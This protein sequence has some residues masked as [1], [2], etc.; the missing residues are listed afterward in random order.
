LLRNALFI[1]T[2]FVI[3]S[4]KSWSKS[5]AEAQPINAI[6]ACHPL[7]W[8]KSSAILDPNFAIPKSILLELQQQ[9]DKLLRQ[10]SHPIPT[11][12]S[13]GKIS[14]DDPLLIASRDAFKDADHAAVLGLTYRLT[15]NINY[16]D[17]A[18][19]ILLSWAEKNQPTGNPIDETRLDGMIWAYDLI[20]CDLSKQDKFLILDWFKRMKEKKIS[21]VFGKKTS[22]NNY[23]IHQLK[24]LLLLN[25]IINHQDDWQKD[26]ATAESYSRINLNPETGVSIDYRERTALYYQN[27][28]LQPW[29]EISLLT[30]CCQQS[31]KKAFSF[32]DKKIFFHQLQG[33]FSHSHAKID[34]LRA[35][36]G[37]AYAKKGKQFDKEKAAPTII[38][39]Y[40]LVRE[41]PDAKLWLIQEQTKSSPKMSFLKSRRLLWQP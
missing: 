19:N 24:M 33:E 12:S 16:L 18:K 34:E 20:A 41:H 30:G 13:S 15:H 1:L 17:K 11:L 14:I 35:K 40:T 31:V 27:Y 5:W 2:L 32:L 28:V 3:I 36:G 9:S 4:S 6:T 7:L 25:K 37:F 26:I 22:V 21:W 10:P 8:P 39:Y 38:I 29:L 23:R